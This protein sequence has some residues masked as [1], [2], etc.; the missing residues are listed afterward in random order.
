MNEL[1]STLLQAVITVAVP[2]LTA[3]GVRFLTERTAAAKEARHTSEAM[4]VI[5]TCVAYISQDY[6]DA[7]KKSG[8]FSRDNQKEA[9]SR[10]LS[11]AQSLLTAEAARFL[12]NAYGDISKY[13]TAKIEAEVK[14]QK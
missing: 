13:L 14:L 10:A 2:I 9:L 1:L 5:T 7:L 8:T 12:E 11:M 6:V 4:D 3:F